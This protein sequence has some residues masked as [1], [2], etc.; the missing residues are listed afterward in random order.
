MPLLP[1]YSVMEEQDPTNNKHEKRQIAM[2]T[3][4]LH[5]QENLLRPQCNQFRLGIESIRQRMTISGKK[6][7]THSNIGN[8][9][10]PA[11]I[12]KRY[13]FSRNQGMNAVA[14][15]GASNSVSGLTTGSKAHSV[16]DT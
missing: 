13:F 1:G 9:I 12:N 4:Q 14:I 10:T 11:A 8:P 5:Q 15:N 3:H 2:L 6:N 7:R 16:S